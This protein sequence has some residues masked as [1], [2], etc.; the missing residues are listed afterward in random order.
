MTKTNN[1]VI[2]GQCTYKIELEN[3]SRINATRV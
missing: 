3:Q 1:S 2:N